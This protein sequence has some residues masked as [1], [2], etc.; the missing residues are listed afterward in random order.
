MDTGKTLF[1][2]FILQK[3]NDRMETVRKGTPRGEPIGFSRSKYLA[4]LLCLYRLPLREI[5]KNA[6]VSYGL[7]R[8]WRTEEEFQKY[9]RQHEKEFALIV[10]AR[11]KERAE[12]QYELD[13]EYLSKPIFEVAQTPPPFLDID[14]FLD[15]KSY[16]LSLI[17]SI[18]ENGI[19]P[20]GEKLSETRICKFITRELSGDENS[21]RDEVY[22]F[23]R[24]LGD[25]GFKEWDKINLL[26]GQVFNFLDYLGASVASKKEVQNMIS[27]TNKIHD[28]AFDFLRLSLIDEPDEERRKRLIFNLYRLQKRFTIVNGE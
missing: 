13:R 5:A 12:K 24:S 25:E 20:I 28:L 11:L 17:K 7:L 15:L 21:R 22:N 4:T 27:K 18:I 9:I 2:R 1:V 8:K 6:R 26:L 3:L 23:L 19:H 14:E 10:K 16:S